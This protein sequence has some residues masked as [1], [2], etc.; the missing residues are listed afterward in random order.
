MVGSVSVALL[1]L[2][3]RRVG[4]RW[5]RYSDS[6]GQLWPTAVN[7]T[8]PFRGQQ[9]LEAELAQ[10]AEHGFDVTVGAE[11]FDEDSLAGLW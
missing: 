3:T 9:A 8:M 6:I 11:A 5:R 10:G 1:R 4:K 2:R 7:L